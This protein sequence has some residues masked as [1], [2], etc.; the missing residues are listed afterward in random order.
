MVRHYG[1]L[2]PLVQLLA[3]AEKKELLVAAT[4]AIWK[5]AISND[6]VIVFQELKAIEQLVALLE[7]QPEDVRTETEYVKLVVD[8]DYGVGFYG[9][10]NK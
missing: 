10:I 9:I 4:G 1:G 2:Q 5:C 6:N 7:N 8:L 3:M